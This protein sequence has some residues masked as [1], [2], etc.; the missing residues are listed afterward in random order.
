VAK[1]DDSSAAATTV[2]ERLEPEDEVFTSEESPSEESQAEESEVDEASVS[3]LV[4]QLGR[5]ATVLGFY[6]AQL[7][8]SRRIPQVR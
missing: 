6:E 7:A 8:A 1:T 2:D 5:D 4:E 3:E